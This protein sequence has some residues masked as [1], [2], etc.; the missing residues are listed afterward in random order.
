MLFERDL[1][2]VS[3]S[4]RQTPL[5]L[6]VG[7]FHDVGPGT[8]EL[9]CQ[10]SIG[11]GITTVS[12]EIRVLPGKIEGQDIPS[13]VEEGE[14]AGPAEFITVFKSVVYIKDPCDGF[15]RITKHLL[16]NR[17]GI[18]IVLPVSGSKDR[19]VGKFGGAFDILIH[20]PIPPRG[21]N[22]LSVEPIAV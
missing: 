2:L 16:G 22:I 20:V 11:E 1:E 18:E 19:Q 9:E 12:T 4:I 7:N 21:I 5:T 13:R 17:E 8:A 14:H 3:D 15:C 10:V 6:C